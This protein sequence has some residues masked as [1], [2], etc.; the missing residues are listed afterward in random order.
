MHMTAEYRPL[1]ARLR[2]LMLAGTAIALC[3]TAP[4]ARAQ[5]QFLN[6]IDDETVVVDM[7]VLDDGGI[8]IGPAPQFPGASSR[9]LRMPPTAAPASRLSMPDDASRGESAV[10][11][12]TPPPPVKKQ[13]AAKPPAPAK[14][15]VPAKPRIA[16]VVAAPPPPPKME[17]PKAPPRVPVTPVEKAE[18]PP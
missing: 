2:V 14:E 18:P 9:G 4:Q 11:T 15:V 17:H 8:G 7:S 16:K 3:F 10:S 6:L 12:F 13:V 5:Q 1:A